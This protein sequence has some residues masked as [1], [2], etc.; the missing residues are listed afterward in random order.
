M[1]IM[2]SALRDE[3]HRLL[4]RFDEEQLPEVERRLREVESRD[5][6][7]TPEERKAL[8]DALEESWTQGETGKTRP[9]KEF[10][11]ELDAR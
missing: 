11:D 7:M 3:L 2:S 5:D 9:L 10:L 1:K 8:D 6:E 4:D